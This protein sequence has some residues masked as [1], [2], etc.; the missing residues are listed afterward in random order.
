MKQVIKITAVFVVLGFAVFFLF[1]PVCSIFYKI[2]GSDK[3]EHGLKSRL[4]K[5]AAQ[6]L[7]SGDV[8]VGAVLIYKN[9]VIGVG[10][11]TVMKDSAAY[12]HAEINSISSA[13]KKTGSGAFYELD[14]NDLQL[15]TTLEP[16]QMCKGAI[17]EYRI[18]HV[19]F[20]KAKDF[21]YWFKENRWQL[22]YQFKKKQV[23]G[24]GMQDS[25]LHLHP[26]YD[27]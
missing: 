11:N 21:A 7:Q 4:A 9:E 15:I 10:Y 3:I 22:L 5:L 24:T 27:D 19:S 1:E 6:S 18:K 8:P 13:M 12:G 16:C 17:V 20:M 26:K 2:K 25:L 23:E 14:R